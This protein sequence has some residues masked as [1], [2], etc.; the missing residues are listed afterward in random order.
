MA[1]AVQ[2]INQNSTLLPGVKLGYRILDSCARYPWALQHALSLV[3]GETNSCNLTVNM[4]LSAAS[5]QPLDTAGT[6]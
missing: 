4:S 3:G 5:E 2:Q 1:F 6:V